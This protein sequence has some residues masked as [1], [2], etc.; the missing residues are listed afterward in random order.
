MH[1]VP[2]VHHFLPCVH[3]GSPCYSSLCPMLIVFPACHRILCTGSRMLP[4]GILAWSSS[5]AHTLLGRIG[6]SLAGVWLGRHPIATE[7][8]GRPVGQRLQFPKKFQKLND[9][10]SNAQLCCLSRRKLIWGVWVFFSWGTQNIYHITCFEEL[11]P[12]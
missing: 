1:P 5:V 2:S 3:Q 12:S 4:G 7:A 8:Q 11:T 10:I 9:T 6:D